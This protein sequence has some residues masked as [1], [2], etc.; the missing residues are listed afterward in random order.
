MTDDFSEDEIFGR[1]LQDVP[2]DDLIAELQARRKEGPEVWLAL[3][4]MIFEQ[5]ADFAQR[6]ADAPK[7]RDE[8][9]K[10]N[11]WDLVTDD[12][13]VEITDGSGN[14][15]DDLGIEDPRKKT[16]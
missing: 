9:V 3:R 10:E 16:W 14:V 8:W 1:P 2:L 15:F 13:D 12:D 5:I 4:K 11:T 6:P 7:W